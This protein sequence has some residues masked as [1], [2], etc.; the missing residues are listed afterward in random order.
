MS[1]KQKQDGAR[2]AYIGEE[3][4]LS[5]VD[6]RHAPYRED[7]RQLSVT[8]LVTNRDLPTLLPRNATRPGAPAWRLDAPGPV[9]RVE[10][11]HGPT[12]PVTRRPVGELGW[13]LVSHLALIHRSLMGETPQ[14]AA[15]TLRRVLDLYS[16]PDDRSWARQVD[17]IRTLEAATAVRRLPFRGPLTFGTGVSIVI[18]LD[19]LAYQGSSAYLF[20][21]VLER[22][23][24]RHASLNTFTQLT[25]RTSQRGEVTRWPPRVGTRPVL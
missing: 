21:S 23:L 9:Q 7:L 24:A 25:L 22:F 8:A 1:P 20:A 5:L 2:S 14:V 3:V 11:I 12:R 17:G 10:V 15:R 18:E 4:F 16:P 13:S 19:E 6:P